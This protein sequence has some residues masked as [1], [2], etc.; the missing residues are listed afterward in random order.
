MNFCS[1]CGKSVVL[2]IPDG[3]NRERHVCPDCDTIHYSN[4][5]IITGC[6]PLFEGKVLL[7]RRAIQPRLGYWTLPAGF[8]E[9]SESTAQ[10]AAR[11]S[12]EEAE[13]ELEALHLYCLYSVPD[14]NQVFF[15]YRSQLKSH[16]SFGVGEESLEVKLFSE[17]EIPWDELAFYT[18]Y[19]TLKYYFEDRKTGEFPIRD[20]SLQRPKQ[21][22]QK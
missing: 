7:C 20:E 19:K 10:G 22:L 17:T 21:F 12:R 8:M 4:P 16:D 14:I 15:F 13:T 3:D 2:Q 1:C 6:L 5:R 11:E 9:N 18:V